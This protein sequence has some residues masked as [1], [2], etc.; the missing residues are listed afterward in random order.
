[1][2]GYP[3]YFCKDCMDPN[4]HTPPKLFHMIVMMNRIVERDK[5]GN[6][7]PRHSRRQKKIVDVARIRNALRKTRR[8]NDPNH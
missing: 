8:R 4:A 1:M 2:K 7:V 5:D 3:K 6:G